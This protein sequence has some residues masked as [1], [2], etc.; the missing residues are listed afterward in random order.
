MRKA[1]VSLQVRLYFAGASVLFVGL[2]AAAVIYLAAG[3]ETSDAANYEIVGG[4]VI[5]IAPEDSKRYIRDIEL[6]G[7]KASVLMDELNRWFSALW[8][9]R[10]L[11]YTVGAL[12][13]GAALVCFFAARHLSDPRGEEQDG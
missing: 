2:L 11:A 10:R 12:T 6:Y 8:R 13:V 7:G 5:A 3:D 1:N 4:D 9:G